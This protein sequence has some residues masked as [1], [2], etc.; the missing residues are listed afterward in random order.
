M[1]TLKQQPKRYLLMNNV[2]SLFASADTKTAAIDYSEAKQGTTNWN[3]PT[4]K[5]SD[6]GLSLS[7]QL[8]NKGVF[9]TVDG[10]DNFVQNDAGAFVST[11]KKTIYN[12]TTQQTLGVMA[13]GYKIAQNEQ[14]FAAALREIDNAGINVE[15]AFTRVRIDND[16]QRV[17]AEIV[18]PETAFDVAVGDTV[19]LSITVSNSFDGSG[20][21]SIKMGAFRFVCANGMVSAGRIIEYKSS[22][23]ANLDIGFAAKTIIGGMAQYNEDKESMLEQAKTPVS[24]QEVYEALCIMNGIDTS[25]APTYDAYQAVIRPALKRQPAIERH[26]ALWNKYKKDLGHTQWALNNVLTHIS[27]HGDKP[28]YTAD[29]KITTRAT[30]EKL[31]RQALKHMLAA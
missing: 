11:G 18:F 29:N 12:V 25:L 13:E 1:D 7:E 22:H 8:R 23:T 20:A 6:I 16:G 19:A 26:M 30:K 10:R 27:T 24:A 28:E 14:I 17:M 3:V 31:V 9:Y 21:F 5:A 4:C 2:I 15:N